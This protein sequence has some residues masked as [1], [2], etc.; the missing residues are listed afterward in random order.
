[1]KASVTST[2]RREYGTDTLNGLSL[3]RCTLLCSNI[4]LILIIRLPMHWVGNFTLYSRLVQKGLDLSVSY[5]IILLVGTWVRYIHLWLRIHLPL[6]RVSLLLIVSC[7]GAPFYTFPI[8]LCM[9]IWFRRCMWEGLM[10]TLVVIAL[11]WWR[12]DSIDQV[13]SA[14]LLGLCHIVECVKLLRVGSKTRDCIHLLWT[15]I[16]F[17]P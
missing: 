17:E 15:P 10:D 3:F 7:L 1:M 16:P 13:S 11:S 4:V 2:L 8:L 14:M 6:S 5:M 9:I 12:I